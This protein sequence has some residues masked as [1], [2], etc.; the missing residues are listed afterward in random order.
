[1]RSGFTFR[2]GCSNT[3]SGKVAGKAGRSMMANKQKTNKQKGFEGGWL[4]CPTVCH[5]L[6]QSRS[7]VCNWADA[8]AALGP[9]M[10]GVVRWR[11]AIL[12][13]P[14]KYAVVP[15]VALQSGL[16]G[17]QSVC[18]VTANLLQVRRSHSRATAEKKR[19]SRKIPTF[20]WARGD[21]PGG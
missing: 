8:M 20:L 7:V 2:R 14:A 16:W 12:A 1:M 15:I 3:Q 5:W 21:K 11:S 10:V 6:E 4:P 17:G 9:L 18:S 19:N 13:C